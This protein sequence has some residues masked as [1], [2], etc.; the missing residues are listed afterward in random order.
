MRVSP[1]ARIQMVVAAQ[2]MP[3]MTPNASPIREAGEEAKPSPNAAAVDG[4]FEY[5]PTVEAEN[6][7]HYLLSLDRSHE[8]KEA[9][10]LI[11][12]KEAAKK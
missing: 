11:K 6:L 3:A 10:T 9:P 8:L 12:P 5:V 2:R 7:A 4:E 1:V